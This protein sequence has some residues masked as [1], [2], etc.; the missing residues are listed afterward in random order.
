MTI[1]EC[2]ICDVKEPAREHVARHF[3]DELLII[4]A[5]FPDPASCIECEYKADKPK[6]LSIHVA[7]VHA[8]LDMFLM[9]TEMVAS[10]RESFMSKPKKLN[11]GPNCPVCNIKFTKT[12]N[13][14]VNAKNN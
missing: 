7:L 10:K 4:V 2:P 5:E 3:S 9:D 14:L 13:R 11:L 1:V 12:Q 8:R 6:T